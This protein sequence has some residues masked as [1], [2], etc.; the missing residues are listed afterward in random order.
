M[1]SQ[2]GHLCIFS[3]PRRARSVRNAPAERGGPTGFGDWINRD[4]K[5][6]FL[7]K[8]IRTV[9][10]GFL[11]VI[12]GVYLAQLGFTP[13]A[14]GIVLTATVLSSAL[15]TLVISFIADR[16]GRRKTLVFFALTDVV[17]GAPLFASQ[18]CWGPGLAGTAGNI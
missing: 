4:G 14:I 18:D 17:A 12:F 2:V 8:T 9:P 10:Y 16:I 7:E 3:R 5:L 6:I 13:V 11:G 15:Y 1:S